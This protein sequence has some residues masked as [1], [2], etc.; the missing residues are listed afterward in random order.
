[1][2]VTGL[3][4]MHDFPKK[5]RL[6]WAQLFIILAGILLY[7]N[8]LDVPFYLDDYHNISENSAIQLNKLTVKSIIEAGTQSPTSKRPVANISFALNYFIDQANVFG[9]HLVNIIIHIVAGLALFLF[10]NLTFKTP[11][12]KAKYPSSHLIAFWAVILWFV[13]P[14][15]TQSV[16]YIV[17][18]MNSMAAMFYIIAFWFY[19]KARFSGGRKKGFLYFGGTAISWLLAMGCK[20]IAATLP[21]LLF[22][23]EWIFFQK[24]EVGWIKKKIPYV[25]VLSVI[26][27][28]IVSLYLGKEPWNTILQGYDS[29]HFSLTERVLTEFRVLFFYISLLFLPIPGRLGLEHDFSLSVSLLQPLSTF[30]AC[31]GILALL[32]YAFAVVRR[33]PLISFSIIWFLGNLVIESSIIP[34]EIIFEHRLYLPSMFFFLPICAIVLQYR[35]LRNISLLFFTF[36]LVLFGASTYGRN[37]D[38]NDPALFWRKNISIAPKSERVHN[39]LGSVL[40]RQG[41]PADAIIYLEEAIQLNP[42]FSPAYNNLGL[43]Y[44]RQRR[45]S[46]AVKYFRK[47]LSYNPN[48]FEAHLNLGGIYGEMGNYQQGLVHLEEAA[49]IKPASAP[50]HNNLANLL[51]LLGRYDEAIRH[52]DEALEYNP[53]YEDARYNRQIAM[54]Q[55]KKAKQELRQ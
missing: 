18:R 21:F 7:S 29:R 36:F 40:L 26:L 44:F 13:H 35:K 47:A 3:D 23:Y 25:V 22:F 46:D 4:E 49:R 17:Q 12:L 39:N 43:A 45:L 34:L 53:Q 32:F 10:V 19:A 5:A 54:K 1:M 37:S 31:C 2:K 55:L 6:P 14:I 51:L 38:W 52:Y 27:F 41:K 16:T 20:E 28:I 48:I 15:Q 30:I 50:V 24:G 8:T 11:A 33:R 42:F 9:Y